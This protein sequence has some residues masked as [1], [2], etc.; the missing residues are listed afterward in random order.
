MPDLFVGRPVILTGRFA[1]Q[2]AATIHVQG[3]NAREHLT[4]PVTSTA[5]NNQLSQAAIPY[6]WARNKIAALAA[7]SVYQPNKQWPAQIRQVAL[8]Y[9]L[10]SDF[11][12]FIAV[13][14]T[15]VTSGTEGTTVPVAVPLPEGVKYETTV[16]DQ[17]ED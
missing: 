16:K 13:D 11:T 2:P 7:Q 10:L 17:K 8:D 1:G 12:A 4:L 6:V 3:D 9:G 15:R 5:A 14:S